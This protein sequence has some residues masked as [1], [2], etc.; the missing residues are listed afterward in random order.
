MTAHREPRRPVHHVRQ[1]G[2]RSRHGRG[3]L[4]ARARGN[5]AIIKGNEADENTR[6]LRAGMEEVIGDGRR[7]GD[8]VTI[9]SPCCETYTDNW[10]A[11]N[12][13]ANMEQCLTATTTRSTRSSSENDG[14]AG[15]VIAAL[16]AQGLAASRSP[17]RTATR[18]RSTAS[19]WAA[20]PSRS[21][22]TRAT[23]ARPPARPPSRSRAGHRARRTSRASST[24]TA[25][26]ATTM[27][28]IFLEP[29]PITQDNLHVAIDAGRSTLATL[30]AD[31][32]AGTRARL[33]RGGAVAALR[34]R[35]AADLA[36]TPSRS[37]PRASD[38]PARGASSS[39][40]ARL[41]RMSDDPAPE[42]AHRGRP[43][44]PP[45]A[46]SRARSVAWRWIHASW[47]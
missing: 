41:Q 26:A 18:P 37:A 30:C 45:A 2:R 40:T 46:R 20:R 4:R 24:S 32:P 38:R 42:H 9:R 28:S 23:S 7:R 6:F 15:G 35:P 16:E 10:H 3:H 8:I 22:R 44:R 36:S 39:G 43:K 12:A 5:Y 29:T 19:R 31:V 47:A 27:T 17:A 34:S 25:P 11:G 21:G 1:R 33:R 13:Q 14:M